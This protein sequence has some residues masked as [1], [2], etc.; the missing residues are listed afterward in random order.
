MDTVNFTRQ[1]APT[2]QDKVPGARWF[3][4]DLQVHTIDDHA[5]GRAKVPSQL[6][7]FP[8]AEEGRRKY[9]RL[10]LGSAASRGIQVLGLTPHSPYA[11]DADASTVWSIVD[12]WNTGSDENGVPFRER[13]YALFPGFEPSFE[14]GQ[15]GLHML[16]LFDP[17]IGP[18]DYRHLFTLIMGGV[19]PW[20]DKALQLSAL[21][22]SEAIERLQKFRSNSE[23]AAGW[24]FLVLAPHIDGQKGL[25]QAQK[26]QV[27]ERFAHGDVAGLELGD[28]K[29]PE[30]TLKNREWLADGMREHR[31]AFFHSSDAYTISDIGNRFAWF[32]LASP[33]ID[34]LRQAMLANDS[35]VRI[36]FHRDAEGSFQPTGWSPETER[37]WLRKVSVQGNAS[38]FGRGPGTTFRLNPD[39][40]CIIGGSM[41]GKSAFL[42]GLRVHLGAAMP[43]DDAVRRQV[44]KRGHDVFAAG[45]PEIL[46]DCPGSDPTTDLKESWP[47]QF[48]GQNELQRLT[49]KGAALVE[50]LARLVPSETAA[51][52]QRQVDLGGLDGE[53]RDLAKELTALDERRDAAEQALHRARNAAELLTAF[54]EVGVEKLARVDRLRQAWAR[55]ERQARESLEAVRGARASA[56]E[57]EV[58]DPKDPDLEE[59]LTESAA[60]NVAASLEARRSATLRGLDSTVH[61]HAAWAEDVRKIADAAASYARK[62]RTEVER[63]LAA[64]GYD[65]AKLREFKDISRQAGLLPSYQESLDSTRKT[66]VARKGQFD[67]L[68]ARRRQLVTQ[69]R[70][71]F[72][73]VASCVEEEHDGGLRLERSEAGD[74]SLLAA[75]LQALKKR[76]ITQWWNTLSEEQRRTAAIK[77]DDFRD[78][79]LRDIAMSSAVRKTFLETM[80]AARRRDLQAMRHPDRYQI[81]YR[82]DDG[83][84]RPLQELSGG[85]RV[86]VLLSLL[87]KA[88]DSRPLVIDQPEDELDNRVLFDTVLP[89]LRQQKGRRQIVLATHN[90]NIVVNGDADMVILLEADANHGTVTLSGAIEM[91]EVRDAIVRTVDGGEDAFRLR[92][93]KYG[94]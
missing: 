15:S 42:D 22:F 54:D 62:T 45:S 31:Q 2:W 90:A 74:T 36:A 59:A 19:A 10:V 47:A 88:N 60:G 7:G 61:L 87:L 89:T 17:E 73:R 41:T 1:P 63:A 8:D 39:L 76:G 6:A 52:E 70:A 13:I 58:P 78:S 48:F 24:S 53:L 91:P 20:K 12:E 14:Q 33:R 30:D 83:N 65:A 32:K 11:D 26:A 29:L 27:L 75:Y 44:Q 38:F 82:M 94:F 4:G 55:L 21:D 9:A 64:R 40:N 84:F 80:T 85:Q 23:N 16:F 51:I 71:A 25:L 79:D 18:A 92:T 93:T 86:S 68:R 34:A 67:R 81:R 56:A 57:L 77:L 37:P 66:V 3:K 49:Q 46:L 69:Q 28:N 50:I 35:R 43:E 5:G 72:D